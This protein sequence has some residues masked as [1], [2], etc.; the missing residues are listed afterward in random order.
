[1][2]P[3]PALAAFPL[4]HS[5]RRALELIRLSAIRQLK[6]RYRGTTLGILWSFM[7]PLLMTAIYTA[8]FGTAF[9]GFF[10]GS[11][12]RYALS[13]FVGVVV[14]TYFMQA[15]SEAMGTVVGNGGLLNKIR[16]SPA[17]FPL[18]SIAANTFQQAVTTFPV[19]LILSLVVTHSPLRVLAL[20]VLTLALIALTTGFS[21]ALAALDVFFRDL[22]QIW[23]IAS[24]V[25]WLSS[26]VFYPA[27][28]A[29]AGVRS[30]LIFNPLAATMQSIRDAT[31]GDGPMD[32]HL[33][34]FAVVSCLVVLAAGAA[35]FRATR[36][37]FM[38][39][40]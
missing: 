10:G 21:L 32:R 18:A 30:L 38:D 12:T 19:L 5:I 39:L 20:L 9:A 3:A 1:M 23:A 26:P 2:A 14:V 36:R 40:L 7:N 22:P 33:M 8:I 6:V 11:L 31:I 15:T 35:L 37:D 28:L 13:A 34:L 16:L 17:I 4:S 29:P 24:F 27:R 25:L